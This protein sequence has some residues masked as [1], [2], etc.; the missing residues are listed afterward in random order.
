M[1]PEQLELEGFR[2]LWYLIFIFNPSL[3]NDADEHYTTGKNIKTPK[4]TT[5]NDVQY[6]V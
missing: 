4:W 1:N 6:V 3:R 2:L 5:N